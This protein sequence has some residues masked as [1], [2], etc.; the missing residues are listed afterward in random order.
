MRSG[1][2]KSLHVEAAHLGYDWA[3]A[4]VNMQY[5][6]FALTNPEPS[7]VQ[8]MAGKVQKGLTALQQRL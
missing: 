5:L 4:V 6:P 8:A 1:D 2:W 3:T 7:V